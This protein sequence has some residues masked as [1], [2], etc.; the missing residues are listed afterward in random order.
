MGIHYRQI[1]LHE[2]CRITAMK[3]QG[4]SNA[5]IARH[6][7]RDRRTIQREL[8]RNSNRGGD[9]VPDTADRRSWVRRLRGSR[10]ERCNHL[11][12][13]VTSSLA[14]GWTPQQ[15]SGRLQLEQGG[16]VISHE[17]IYRYIHSPQGRQQ[18]LSRYLPHHHAKRGYRRR[19][20]ERKIPIP[21]R[22]PIDQRPQEA[23]DRCELGHWEGDLVHFTNKGDILLTLQERKS[24]YW[25][26]TAGARARQSDRIQ[27]HYRNTPSVSKAV[28]QNHHP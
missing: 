11:R 9:Y 7:G 4:F 20:G 2:R 26:L 16:P 24:R 28:S 17:S 19:K 1:D 15:I 5:A 23:N 21:D 18:R 6:L 14:M 13:A 22:V 3:E 25:P 27:R 12:E 8:S 10:I